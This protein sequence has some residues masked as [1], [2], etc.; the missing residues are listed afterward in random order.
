MRQNAHRKP[1]RP[2]PGASCFDATT[3]DVRCLAANTPRGSTF[4]TSIGAPKA[5]VT[6]RTG[7]SLSGGAHHRALHDGTLVIEGSASKGLTFRHADG[8]TYG[9]PAA[10]AL[11]DALAKV[12]KALV[13]MGFRESE[14]KGAVALLQKQRHPDGARAEELLRLC[15][16]DLVPAPKRPGR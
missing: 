13:N 4:T 9:T 6:I 15:L 10:P 2:R 1:S 14:A 3:V 7:S 5:A 16:L 12:F 11:A 8:S